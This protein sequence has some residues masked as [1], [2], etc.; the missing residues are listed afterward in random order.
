[1]SKDFSRHINNIPIIPEIATKIMGIAE[2][3][4]NISFKELENIIKI[5]PG[6]TSKILK[7]ANSALYARQSD[8]TSLQVAITLLGFKNIKSL[9]LLVTASNLFQR[10]KNTEFYKMFWKH[11][12]IT[13]FLGKKMAVQVNKK[14]IAERIFI[15]GLLHNIGQALLYNTD[16]KKYEEVLELEKKGNDFIE[17]YEE[18]IFGTT[19][20]KTG[21]DIFRKW[22][23][24][25][26]YIDIVQEHNSL[27]ITSQHKTVIIFVTIASLITDKIGYGHYTDL[28]DDLLKKLIPHISM[29]EKDVDFYSETLSEILM[30]DPIFSECQLL[31]GFK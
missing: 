4:F 21:A 26:I 6:L 15:G 20:R 31:F 5:D 9:V 19:H 14:D 11:S 24:P 23:F 1:L 30:N 27:Y 16:K 12:I 2:D 18:K 22:T 3:R 29:T 25:E 8:I 7:V 10:D 28:K 13:A 17:V